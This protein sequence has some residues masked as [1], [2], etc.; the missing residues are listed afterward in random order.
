MTTYQVVKAVL[1]ARQNRSDY[2]DDPCDDWSMINAWT[3][4]LRL[5]EKNN[6]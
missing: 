4:N 1:W 6:A 2:D 3:N 5:L